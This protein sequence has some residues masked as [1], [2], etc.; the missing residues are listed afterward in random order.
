MRFHITDDGPR[1]CRASIRSC[2]IGGKEEHFST[3]EDAATAF[4]KRM[5]AQTLPQAQTKP[6][7]MNLS[8]PTQEVVDRLSNAGIRSLIVGGSVRDQFIGK[9]SKD[10]D[11][12]LYGARPDGSTL[13]L[14]DVSQHFPKSD[15]FHVDEAGAS[16][17]VLKIRYKNEDFDVALPR[18]EQSTG[19]HHRDYNTQHDSTMTFE[20]ASSRRDFTI[21]SMGYDP[22]SGELLDPYGGQEDLQNRVLR[23]VSPAFSDDPLRSLRA[24]NF[25]S[26][27]NLD[28]APETRSLCREL[29]PAYDTLAK[30]R[31]QEE[32]DKVFSKGKHVEKAFGTLHDIGWAQRMEPFKDSSREELSRYGKTL[33]GVPWPYRKTA[34]S[35]M[36]RENKRPDPLPTLESSTKE[37]AFVKK[38]LE[39]LDASEAGDWPRLVA[40]HRDLKKSHPTTSNAEIGS[41]LSSVGKDSSLVEDLPEQPVEPAVTGKW[42]MEKGVKP[43]PEMGRVIKAAQRLQDETGSTDADW[44][45][46]EVNKS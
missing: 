29:A 10:I 35:Y 20:E 37:R 11:F 36:L 15:G 40:A 27:F 33:D 16:F 44:L 1:P 30:E 5:S 4:E 22:V 13:Q 6:F 25:V 12:E 2:P 23:H 43:G 28:V 7:S 46:A 19:D 24:V 34:L 14:S 38:N 21:N 3:R 32:F 18:T 39:V 31:V 8:G 17:S 9:D 41:F 26:R 45:Y 42:L